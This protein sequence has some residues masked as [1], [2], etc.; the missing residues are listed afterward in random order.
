[1]GRKIIVS[2]GLLAAIVFVLGFLAGA[3]GNRV[4]RNAQGEEA[5]EYLKA[6]S[7]VLYIVKK[8]YVDQ[9]KVAM[10]RRN[11]S[12]GVLVT[13][14]FKKGTAGFWV[15]KGILIVHPYGAVYVAMV[16]R[17][18]LIELHASRADG[19]AL[20]RRSRELMEYIKG[21][22]FRNAVEGSIYRT[23]MLYDM[24]VKEIRHHRGVW[25]DRYNHYKSIFENVTF[26]Q[27]ATA[28]IVKGLPPRHAL[29]PSALPPLPAPD[30]TTD[31]PSPADE[32]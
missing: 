22:E 17:N 24:L 15:E 13:S 3:Q 30:D 27:A 20:E 5:Y 26:M 29:T 31:D 12:F 23:R 9:V 16:L 32:N 11:T 10:G 28:N 18:L 21:E 4:V 19:A 7:D 25:E 14:A 1:M 2:V 6:F 8:D